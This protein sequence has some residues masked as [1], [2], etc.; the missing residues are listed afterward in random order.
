M[1]V[2][3]VTTVGTL[4]SSVV[5]KEELNQPCPW[6]YGLEWLGFGVLSVKIGC[7]P[8]SG[9]AGMVIAICQWG[10]WHDSSHY[11][12]AWGPLA[13]PLVIKTR[14][15][16]FHRLNEL[17][18]P[19]SHVNDS[20]M[21]DAFHKTLSD[22][23]NFAFHATHCAVLQCLQRNWH[24]I[25]TPALLPGIGHELDRWRGDPQVC[26]HDELQRIRDWGFQG[27]FVFSKAPLI[28]DWDR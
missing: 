26:G 9:L 3:V 20:L 1:V 4:V 18:E 5:Q 23:C 2:D 22:L 11:W 13:I 7:F 19:V 6:L 17:F 8:H 25:W 15:P 27:H 16:H 14:R 10:H 21:F 28:Q 24:R 12:L